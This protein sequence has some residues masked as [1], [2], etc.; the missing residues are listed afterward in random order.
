MNLLMAA[1]TSS[2]HE[3][4]KLIRFTL[5]ELLAI[6]ITARHDTQHGILFQ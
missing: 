6:L 1:T 4:E 3:T 5:I 2:V